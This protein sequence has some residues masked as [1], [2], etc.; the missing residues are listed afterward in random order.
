MNHKIF[1]FLFLTV[2]ACGR[3]LDLS[4]ESYSQIFFG[5]NFNT[6]F[7]IRDFSGEYAGVHLIFPPVPGDNQALD[8]ALMSAAGMM[9]PE[10]IEEKEWYR[11]KKSCGM[12][13][14]GG[15]TAGVLYITGIWKRNRSN[16]GLR[17]F[18]RQMRNGRITDNI[19][20]RVKNRMEGILED[21]ETGSSS[22]AESELEKMMFGASPVGTR[23]EMK[24]IDSII[25]QRHLQEKYQKNSKLIFVYGP[26][27]KKNVIEYLKK[28]NFN[29]E[30]GATPFYGPF[31][32]S[33][34]R[35]R[36]NLVNSSEAKTTY[37]SCGAEL[38][39]RS[40][41]LWDMLSGFLTQK[42]NSDSTEVIVSSSLALYPAIKISVTV[43]SDSASKNLR[44]LK[45][46]MDNLKISEND[47][48]I[49]RNAWKISL[50]KK[51]K[52]IDFMMLLDRML[53][54][55][56]MKLKHTDVLGFNDAVSASRILKEWK[57]IV[58]R[59]VCAGIGPDSKVD[60]TIL[61]QENE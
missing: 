47:I 54:L 44:L 48:E 31:K 9:I 34:N 61:S 27:N 24:A 59:M 22:K 35:L 11:L 5:D 20:A 18:F 3:Y 49:L 21:I 28:Q 8:Y 43:D 60:M 52:K 19:W 57:G 41:A 51:M 14:W 4:K 58:N 16:D 29:S 46:L 39:F 6:T 37:I 50:L 53:Y 55:D 42:L 23:D 10:N 17:L 45:T 32:K 40:W 2:P 25:L 38:S 30:I 12:K 36:T 7:I 26:F 1:L 15:K 33:K 56:G 13:T